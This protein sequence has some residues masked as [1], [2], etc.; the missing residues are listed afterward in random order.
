MSAPESQIR[1]A[2]LEDAPAL[3][4]IYSHYC[5]VD[6]ITPDLDAPSLGAFRDQM[7]SLRSFFPYVVIQEA[8]SGAILGYSFACSWHPRRAFRWVAEA[9]IYIH[10]DYR[11]L[12]LGRRLYGAL[13][14]AL[15]RQGFV[16]VY[17]RIFGP[18]EAAKR[19]HTALG[20]ARTTHFDHFLFKAGWRAGEYWSVQVNERT[21]P[22]D[23]IRPFAEVDKVGIIDIV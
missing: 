11:R 23:E 2:T 3:L 18:N 7:R 5:Q 8:A 6:A 15:R 21:N 22:P 12:G 16:L 1:V 17:A 14:V 4:A 13:L 10:P 9:S 19:L 20:F